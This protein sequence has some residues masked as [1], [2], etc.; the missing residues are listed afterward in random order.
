M[1][2]LWLLRHAKSAWDDP[3]LDDFARPLSSRGKKACRLLARHM[4]ERN[5][6]PDLVLCSP[7]TRT[8]QTWERLAKRLSDGVP[9][10]IPARFEPALYLA[11]PTTLLALIR[12]AP[13]DCRELLLI[14]HNPGL[15]EFA[16]RLAGSSAGDA[17]ERLAEKFPTGGLAEIAF[18]V[19]AW[20]Q[21]GPKA[22]FLASF[23]VPAQLKDG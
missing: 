23:V 15:E 3:S 22:G 9:D 16:G 17:L 21:V 5:I 12:A 7:A 1:L 13:T 20:A 10:R 6:C 2:R 8:R 19:K 11:E 4:G 14:G 18:P